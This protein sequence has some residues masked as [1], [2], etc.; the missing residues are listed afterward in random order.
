M[1]KI[2]WSELQGIFLFILAMLTVIV[3]PAED[4]DVFISLLKSSEAV[5]SHLK[6][7][8]HLG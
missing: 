8:R 2:G 1:V 6:L 4:D 3:A 7:Q 5:S